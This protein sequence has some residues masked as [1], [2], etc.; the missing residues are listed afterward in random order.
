[1]KSGKSKI[2][3]LKP[4]FQNFQRN[5]QDTH[6]KAEKV[7]SHLLSKLRIEIEKLLN[8][9]GHF[10]KLTNCLDQYFI[11]PIVITLKQE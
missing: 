11:L 6:Q 9:E 3:T 2:D 7:S 4:I 10:K 5:Y 1:M 8:E